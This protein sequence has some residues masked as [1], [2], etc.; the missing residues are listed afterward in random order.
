MIL[1]ALA[2]PGGHRRD[3]ADDQGRDRRTGAPPGPAGPVGARRGGDGRRRLRGGA[4]VH[5]PLAGGARHHGR[6]GR[7]PQGPLRAAADP[8]DVVP[9]P[10]AVR[11]AAVANHER[12]EHDSP[13]PVVRPGLPDAQRPADHRRDRRSC[14]RCTGRWVW[15]CWCRSCRSPRPCCTSSGSTPGCRGWPRTSP[16]TSPPTS[17]S[18]RSG[19]RVVKSF[20]REDYV[21]DRFD[22]QLTDLYDTQVSRVVG[23]GEV[24]DA[25]RGHSEPDA[26]RRAGLRRLR[27]RPRLRHHGHARRVH[28]DDAVA[29]VADRVAGL[30]AVDDAGVVHRGQPD[31]RDLRRATR[32]HRRP[33]CR[34]RRAAA[35]SN[36]STSASD[37]PMPR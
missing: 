26:D 16:A 9:R 29:G 37:S 7:H 31:R 12:P 25:A 2:Q 14:W 17:R 24:L 3:P 5:P 28:H 27:R 21:Y 11:S 20:G 1:V 33:A 36:S 10:L 23:V 4:V 34:R 13:V 6:R 22:E 32:D 8:A 35:G 19:L 18:P 15:W 30:P